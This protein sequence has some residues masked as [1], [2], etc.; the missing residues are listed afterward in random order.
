MSAE[1]AGYWPVVILAALNF[2]LGITVLATIGVVSRSLRREL[3]ERI[4]AVQL[5]INRRFGEVNK[6]FEEVNK[7]FE[8]VNKR[9]EEVNKRIAGVRLEMSERFGE[10]NVRI[11]AVRA[12]LNERITAVQLDLGDRLVRVEGLVEGIGFVLRKRAGKER[13][14]GEDRPAP[15]PS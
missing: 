9:F 8:E 4:T 1:L 11:T 13:S 10:V 12:E 5:E 7:R 14:G 6:R 2:G 3:G 15:P